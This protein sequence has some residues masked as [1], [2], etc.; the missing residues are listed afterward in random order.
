MIRDNIQF[1]KES[2]KNN[3]IGIRNI[4][5]KKVHKIRYFI[6]FFPI[7]TIYWDSMFLLNSPLL[8]L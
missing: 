2:V 6:M 1:F 5:S 3:I 7:E 4:C 8:I